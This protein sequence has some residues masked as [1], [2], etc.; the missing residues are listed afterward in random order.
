[1]AEF[2][3][4]TLDIDDLTGGINDFFSPDKIGDNQW[5]YARNIYG[6]Q[7]SVK[8]RNGYKWLSIGSLSASGR[9]VKGLGQIQA[10]ASNYNFGC[11][12]HQLFKLDGVT[13]QNVS[14]VRIKN[15]F[16]TTGGSGYIGFDFF[17]FSA[18]KNAV[19]CNGIQ[20]PVRWDGTSA[21]VVNLSGSAPATSDT[22]LNA[23]RYGLL[24]DFDALTIYRSNLG[25]AN[26]G[27]GSN[28]PIVIPTDKIGDIGSGFIQLGDDVIATTR[29]SLHKLI[30][31]GVSTAP[32]VRKRITAEVGNLS[33]RAM[34]SI[35]NGI[36]ITDATGIYFYDGANLVRASLPIQGTWDSINQEKLIHAVACNYKPKNWALFAV[37]YGSGQTTN[38]LILA[39][40]Y[41]NSA[42]QRGKFVWWMFDNIT[43][44][45]MG[46]F[47]NSS[48]VDEWWTGNNDAK[49][50][51]QDSG[52]NDAGAAFTQEGRSKAFDFKKPNVD[53]RLHEVRYVLDA[54]GNWSL[55]TQIDIDRQNSP[56][57]QNTVSLYAG[58]TLWGSFTWGTHSWATQGTLQPRKKYASTVRGRFIQFRFQVSTVDQFFRL[59]RYLPSISYKNLRGRDVYSE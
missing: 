28:T 27:Y 9:T 15:N 14:A 40:D 33:H 53:K 37:P 12:N 43:A 39:Y 4:Q 29:R 38:N 52:T 6:Y 3:N 1:M 31:T 54:S 8:S 41:L 47:R 58:G 46:I 2:K 5:A 56:A 50:F 55:T 48:L 30:P 42:P 36:L 18:T 16:N 49:L 17:P 32:F 21:G 59:Y 57:N 35:D 22:F 45:A 24:Y 44:Q 11:W 51:L 26:A 34:V 19:I 20:T 13:P 25:D 7:N 23:N 10:G